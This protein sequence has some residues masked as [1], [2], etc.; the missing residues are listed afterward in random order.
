[1]ASITKNGLPLELTY[2]PVQNEIFFENQAQYTTVAKGRR[3]GATHGAFNFVIESLISGTKRIL[4]VDTIYGNIDKYIE[5]Y[6]FPT[7]RQL[8]GDYW[9]WRAQKKELSILGNTCDFRSADRPQNIEGFAYDIIIL[10]E[11]GIILQDRYLWQNAI[12][13]MCLDYQARVWF[14]GTPKGKRSKRD[15]EEHEYYKLYKRGLDDGHRWRSFKF[16]TYDNP[17]LNPVDIKEVEEEVPV[18]IRR[19]EI[20][21]EFI[22]SGEELVFKMDWFQFIEDM[23]PKPAILKIVQSWDTAFKTKAENDYSVCTTWAFTSNLYVCIDLFRKKL[24]FPSLLNEATRLYEVYNPDLVLIEDKASG[25]SLIQTLRKE[26]HIPLKPIKVDSDKYTR[27]CS[28]SSLIETGKAILLR[29]SWNLTLMNEMAEFP[30]GGYDD[31]VDSVDQALIYAKSLSLNS[32]KPVS[33]KIIRKS[34]ILKGY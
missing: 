33:R 22:E 20:D 34:K 27:A 32:N 29:S 6:A 1:M 13:P 30:G 28:V 26:T 19:Q 9:S 16:S 3:L 21:G 11:A 31:I 2:T 5:R 18:N 17:L 23:P 25:Q 8:K 7:M 4:W 24:D 10:N 15:G 14:L 12:R